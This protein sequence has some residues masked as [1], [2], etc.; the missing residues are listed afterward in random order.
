MRH[1][2]FHTNLKGVCHPPAALKLGVRLEHGQRFGFHNF[3]HSPATFLVSRGK[4]VKTTQ[5]VLRHAKA[6]T[7]LDLYSQAIDA[8]KLAAQQEIAAA[9]TSTAIAADLTQLQ[10]KRNFVVPASHPSAIRPRREHS[11]QRTCWQALFQACRPPSFAQK[12]R[13]RGRS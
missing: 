10:V 6:S 9:I 7:T 1:P 8:T 5:E 4:D 12:K 2:K 11:Q 13:A 3:R